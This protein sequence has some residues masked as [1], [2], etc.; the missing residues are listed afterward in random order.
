LQG[1]DSVQLSAVLCHHPSKC[2]T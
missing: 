1:I 2:K